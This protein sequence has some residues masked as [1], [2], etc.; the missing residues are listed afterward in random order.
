MPTFCKLVSFDIMYV[1]IYQFIFLF[2]E[3]GLIEFYNFLAEFVIM[4]GEKSKNVE[5]FKKNLEKKG[6]D[7]PVSYLTLS[8][9]YLF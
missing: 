4:L 1:T 2:F 8:L 3:N 5:K 6:A 7:F 9:C